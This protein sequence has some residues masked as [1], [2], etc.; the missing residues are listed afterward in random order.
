MTFREYI[1]LRH[2]EMI[3]DTVNYPDD[4]LGPA[5]GDLTRQVLR[6]MKEWGFQPD[7]QIPDRLVKVLHKYLGAMSAIVC[8]DDGTTSKGEQNV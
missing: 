5:C 1:T 7:D 4:Q 2:L 6:L 3:E 8:Y